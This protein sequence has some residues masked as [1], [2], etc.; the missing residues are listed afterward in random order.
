MH[1]RWSKCQN[2]YRYFSPK[3]TLVVHQKTFEAVGNLIA[4]TGKRSKY[5]VPLILNH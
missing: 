1:G 3:E 4:K 2:R 5:S